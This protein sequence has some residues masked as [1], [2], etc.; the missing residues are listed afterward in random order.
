MKTKNRNS[1]VTYFVF[2]LILFLANSCEKEEK[3]IT[4]TDFDGNVYTT[5]KIG[6]QVWTVENLRVTKYNDG[7]PI[8]LVTEPTE[9][10][11]LTTPGFSWYDNDEAAYKDTYGAM[12]NWHAVNTGKLCP[13]GWHVPTDAD[14]TTL[15]N[16]LGGDT[17]AGGMLKTAGTIEDGDGQ[18]NSPNTGATNDYGFSALPCGGHYFNGVFGWMGHYGTCWTSTESASSY[19]WAYYMLYNSD[20]LIRGQYDKK[21]GYSVRCIKD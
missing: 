1:A 16:Y 6:T 19:A 15:S 21:I 18:W 10:A 17:I 14:W 7:T 5:V 9:W 13:E 20:D 8:P 3:K 11:S 2:G 12:Y 4:M